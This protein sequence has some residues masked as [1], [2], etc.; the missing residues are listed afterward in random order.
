MIKKSNELD[1]SNKKFSMIIAGVPG[2]GK[3]TLALSAPNPLLVDIDNGVSRV[4]AIYR[5]DT[6]VVSSYEELCSDLKNS[7]LSSYDTIVIDTG[8]KLLEMMKPFVGQKDPKNLKRDG[9]LS[10]QGYGAVKKEFTRFTTAVKNLGK[11]VIF[12]FHASEVNI[13]DD[14]TGLRIRVEGKTRDEV[15]DDIDIGGF[16]EMKGNSR[17]IGFSNCERYYAKGTHGIHGTYEIPVLA[18]GA[19]NAFVTDLFRKMKEDLITEQKEADECSAIVKNGRGLL[20][21]VDGIESFNEAVK[22][23]GG[24]NHVL[25]SRDELLAEVSAMAKA[26]GFKY[27]KTKKEYIA[28]AEVPNHTEPVK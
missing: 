10:L 27:D 25:T 23:I 12:V 18:K 4:E 9:S 1:F 7:D 19:K 2:I 17:T 20:S 14:T 8:G 6:D 21:K 3:T 28:N 13:S 5:K 11:N 16:M 15:W 22:T 26:K 24:M